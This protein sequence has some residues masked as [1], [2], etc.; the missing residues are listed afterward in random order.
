MS[1]EEGILA[2]RN[3][4]T[5]NC[6]TPYLLIATITNVTDVMQL[7]TIDGRQD[8]GCDIDCAMVYAMRIGGKGIAFFTFL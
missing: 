5:H 8:M 6:A 1:T 7:T 2:L 3:S 4:V